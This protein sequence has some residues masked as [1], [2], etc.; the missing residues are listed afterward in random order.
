MPGVSKKKK[1]GT[2]EYIVY[3]RCH[4]ADVYRPNCGLTELP[5]VFQYTVDELFSYMKVIGF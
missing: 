1:K 3:K 4:N 2:K 5:V